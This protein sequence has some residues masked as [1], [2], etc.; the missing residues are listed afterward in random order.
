MKGFCLISHFIP[1]HFT[2]PS[3]SSPGKEGDGCVLRNRAYLTTP[4]MKNT[5]S[6]PESLWEPHAG[7]GLSGKRDPSTVSAFSKFLIPRKHH[8][9]LT[10]L[11]SSFFST[12]AATQFNTFLPDMNPSTSTLWKGMRTP[13][14]LSDA[15][16]EY[17]DFGG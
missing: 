3:H 15:S 13:S 14:S 12:Q 7:S 16:A 9:S 8:T 1:L 2:T 17:E 10:Q 4:N 5:S 6:L 11:L